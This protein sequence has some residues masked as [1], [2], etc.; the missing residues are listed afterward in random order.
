M[1]QI[2]SHLNDKAWQVAVCADV[3]LPLRKWDHKGTIWAVSALDSI[4][5][6]ASNLKL[7]MCDKDLHNPARFKDDAGKVVY[8]FAH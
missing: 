1:A 2:S 3:N 4:C 7:K 6:C 8:I 5:K